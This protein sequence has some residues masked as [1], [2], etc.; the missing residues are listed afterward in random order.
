[1]NSLAAYIPQDRCEALVRNALLPEHTD[2]AALFADISGFTPLTEALR[3]ALGPRRG[4]EAL[5]DQINTTYDALIA[6]VDAYHGSVIGFAGDAIT[7]WFDAGDGPAARRAAACAV[8]MQRAMVAFAHVFLP[9]GGS[10]ALALKV[11]VACGS[12][13][14]L[15]VGDPDIQTLDLLAGATVARVA[16]AEH[17]AQPGEIVL[18]AACVAA[19]G[20]AATTGTWREDATTGERFAPLCDLTEATPIAPWPELS[21]DALTP[22]LLQPWLLPAVYARELAGQD[23]FLTELRPAVALF[24]RFGGIDYDAEPDAHARLDRFIR[25]AQ[26]VLA[27]FGGALLQVVIGDKGSYLCGAFGAPVAYEDDARRAVLAALT[28]QCQAIDLPPPQIG[29]S[30]GTMRCGAYGSTSRRTYGILGDEVNLAARLMGLAAPGEI[31]ISGDVRAAVADRVSLEPRSPVRLKGKAEPLPVFAVGGVRQERA[32]RL[33]E[34]TY[35]LPMVGR[36]AELMQSAHIL[37]QALAGHG[38]VLGIIAE[39]GLGKSRLVAEIIR[40]AHQRAMVGYGGGGQATGMRSPYLVWQSIWRAIFNCDPEA[41]L[42]RQIRALEGFVDDWA[43][44]RADATPLL[45]PLLGLPL[46]ESAFTQRLEPKDRQG[47]LHALL[48]D[49]LAAAAHEAQA[50]GGGLLIVLDDAHWIDAASVDL[51]IDLARTIPVLPVLFVLAYRPLDLDQPHNLHVEGLPSFTQIHLTG[52]DAAAAEQLIQAK[53]LQ[54]FPTRGGAVP[55]T[56]VTQLMARTQGNPFYLEELLNYLHDREIDPRADGAL[57]SLDLPASLHRLILSRLDQLSAQQQ[58]ILKVSSVIGRR[59][60]VAWLRGAF[61]SLAPPKGLATELVELA[62]LELTPLDT[63]EPELAYLFKHVVTR[64]VA[65]ES[66]GAATRAALHGQLASYLERVADID[67]DA[68]LDVLAYH[69]EQSDHLAKK[70]E[71]LRRAGHAAAARYANAAALAYLSRALELAPPDDLRE[72]YALLL[73]REQIYGMQGTREAQR[74]DMESLADLADHLADPAARSEVALRRARYANSTGDFAAAA[75]AAQTA[76]A[77]ANAVSQPR[78]AATAHQ[79]LGFALRGQGRYAQASEQLAESLRLATATDDARQIWATLSDIAAVAREQGDYGEARRQSDRSLA[80]ARAMGDRRLESYALNDLAAIVGQQGDLSAARGYL[81][82]CR[83]AAHAV[84]DRWIEAICIGNLGFVQIILGDYVAARSYGAQ[85]LAL[86]NETGDRQQVAYTYGNLG[87]AA[88]GQ[89][90]SAGAGGY[91]Q[92]SL[93]LAEILGDRFLAGLAQRGLGNVALV[94]GDLAAS[95]QAFEASAAI[96]REVGSPALVAEA[97]AGLARVTLA[98][99]DAPTALARVEEV[100]AHLEVGTLDGAEEP[101][102]VYLAC[103]QALRANGDPRA[104]TLLARARAELLACA[105]QIADPEARR[106]FL[107]QVPAHREIMAVE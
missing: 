66:L 19:L 15:V 73:A 62:E 3:A 43:P 48:R 81:E 89:D 51:L 74:A 2:G 72:R 44:E 40:L 42:R 45:G 55:A 27:R 103:A 54:L 95:A 98:R 29:I 34:P 16:A 22:A 68:M 6:Q 30:Q 10:T 101:M 25:A 11:A 5:T 4:S 87:L 90:D 17:H 100:L 67:T 26:G 24:V 104:P 46:P 20:A 63:P 9:G 33:P 107:E 94:R 32:V 71:Y 7:C 102:K 31:L 38:Q 8:G 79:R 83:S 36:S 106:A 82:Q 37:D 56:L 91:F 61:P 105:A 92:Q 85:S 52:L 97:L 75:V 50:V 77:Q 13:R 14:R 18:D 78:L 21:A 58:V 28:L 84:G 70:R 65:Y 96:L 1:M 35:T 88:L 93:A 69:Y 47:A 59:F 49:S 39:A 76:I 80:V 12:A 64:E 60:L 86:A 41:P 99:G 57:E 53:L 23:A